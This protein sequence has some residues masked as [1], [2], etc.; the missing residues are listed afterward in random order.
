ML[1]HAGKRTWRP[2]RVVSVAG[3]LL[4]PWDELLGNYAEVGTGVNQE[5]Q[6]V[7]GP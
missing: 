5:F 6:V 2:E 4:A 7:S 1:K 3:G